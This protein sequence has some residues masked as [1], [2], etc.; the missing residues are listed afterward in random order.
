M[1]HRFLLLG[2][3]ALLAACDATSPRGLPQIINVSSYDPKERQRSGQG[4]TVDDVSALKANGA[5]SLIARV[6]KGTV[7]DDKCERFLAAADRSGMRVGIYFYFQP[8]VDAETQAD[9]LVSRAR[10]IAAS[11]DWQSSHLLLCGDYDGKSTASQIARFMQRVEKLTGVV[12]VAYLENSTALKLSLSQ[13][14]ARTRSVLRQAPYWLALYSHTSGASAAFPA[15]ENPKGLVRQ[16]GVWDNWAI[17]QYGGVEWERGRSQP[18]VYHAGS[19]RFPTYFGN[20]DRPCERNVFQGSEAELTSLWA[21]HG[22]P[23]H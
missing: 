23:L 10:A 17:W 18:K 13:A 9:R 16:Y 15:P 7:T 1:T 3:C 2:L 12:P 20:L 19:W 5:T 22:I 14:D 21:R 4:Y 8:W 6:A 11:R